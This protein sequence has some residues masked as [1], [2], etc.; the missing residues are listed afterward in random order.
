MRNNTYNGIIIAGDFN[1]HHPLWNPSNYHDC[2][3]EA[4]VL[5]DIMSQ[6]QLKPMLPTGTITF[7]PAKTTIDL[8]WGNEYI[9][10]RIIKCRIAKSCEHGS[11]HHPIETILN[12]H[13]CPYGLEARQPYNY[14]KTDW[15]VFEKKL[16]DYLPTIDPL[17][18]PT[19]EEVDQFAKDIS[20]A[21]RRAITE[22]TPRANICPFSKRWWNK[23]IEI[24]WKQVQRSRRRFIKYERWEDEDRWKKNQKIFQHKVEESKRNMWQNF[25]SKVDERDIWKVNK[26]LNSIPTN[27][28]IPTLEGKAA[29]NVQKT[30]TLSRTFFPPP[31][32]AD[33]S[34]I[35]NA[36]YPE[37]VTTNLNITIVQIKGAIEKLAPNKTPGPDEIP[38]HI[39][40]RCLTILQHHIL[41]L[42]QQSLAMGHFPQPF[43][44]T[45]T[46]VLRKPNKP[47]YIRPNAYRPIAL[48]NTIGKVLESIMAD[49]ISYLCETFNLLP[50]NHF[51]GRPGRTTEDA[52]LILSESIY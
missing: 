39:L 5:I 34:N 31:P 45:I 23:D 43:K 1:L 41:A 4:E 22:T 15:K 48:E 18:E 38:N 32:A 19:I 14:S 11:D 3:P 42:A 12:L 9:E 44:E 27:T 47:N 13:P 8:V 33:L 25:V 50:K 10:R 16:E 36:N 28:Y 6:L 49:H 17:T 35:P 26:Y 37:S 46:L 2:D 24:L 20:E 21:I 30:E 51:G 29:T 40:K 7:I 52:M